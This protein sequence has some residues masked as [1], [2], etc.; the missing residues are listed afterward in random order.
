MKFSMIILFSVM[1]F[2][3]T[4][5]VP[6]CAET[7]DKTVKKTP[8]KRIRA[9]RSVH[10][11]YKAPD[12]NVYYNE[13]TVTKSQVNSYFC[14]CGFN[15]GYFGIQERRN[16]KV[17]IFSIWDPGKQ[18]NPNEVEEQQR[19]KLI[20]KADDVRVGRFGNEGTGGQSFFEYDWKPFE[21]YKFMVKSKVNG[22]RTEYSGFFYLNEKKQWKHL[23]TFS[24]I[25][26]G[27]N[28]KGYYA[29]IEDF[30]RDYKSVEEVRQA[31]FSNGWVKTLDGYWVSLTKA[32]FTADSNTLMN[33]NAWPV[34]D[35]FYLQTGGDT[36]NET[37]LWSYMERSPQG[38]TVPKQVNA[39][40]KGEK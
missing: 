19:V 2:C 25:T 27:D 29:F 18:N 31:H 21:T 38:L 35:G 7:E 20:Y 15:H 32:R 3:L 26:K 36:K 4:K 22:N 16:D 5:M 37:K 28:L 10:L 9:A 30:R 24:T 39:N 23:V 17:V 13:V 8:A 40:T 12:A 6:V 33:I 14:V 34:E 11:G 1:C